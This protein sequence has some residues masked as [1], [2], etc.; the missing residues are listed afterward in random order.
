MCSNMNH[1]IVRITGS[2]SISNGTIDS[3]G[4]RVPR[5]RQM[6][7]T[8]SPPHSPDPYGPNRG[9]M[10]VYLRYIKN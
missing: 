6:S 10:D 3:D 1:L 8:I 7:E 5:G 2:G 4:Y 9:S